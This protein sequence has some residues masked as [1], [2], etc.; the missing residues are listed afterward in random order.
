MFA[1]ELLCRVL[2]PQCIFY[3]EMYFFVLLCSHIFF[4]YTLWYEPLTKFLNKL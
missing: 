3:V 1:K 2:L 4:V